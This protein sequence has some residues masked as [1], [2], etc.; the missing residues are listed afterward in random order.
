MPNIF[1]QVARLLARAISGFNFEDEMILVVC[2]D[3]LF[4]SHAE[5]EKEAIDQAKKHF[6]EAAE[7]ARILKDYK[8]V[9]DEGILIEK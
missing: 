3:I 5:T 1:G 4:I 8:V 2:K 6:P 9:W 7:S